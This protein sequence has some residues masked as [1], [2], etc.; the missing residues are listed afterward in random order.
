M[1]S[2]QSLGGVGP[3][4]AK[5]L[6][7]L[8]CHNVLSI[9]WHLPYAVQRR[10]Y[11]QNLGQAVPGE[12]ITF[13][14]EVLQHFP[15]S[16]R[17]KSGSKRPY[18]IA[19]GDSTRFLDLIFF[20]GRS[21]Y[22]EQNL[23]V[24]SQRL[25]S[26]RFEN[27]QGKL[28]ITHPDHV[29]SPESLKE[30]QGVEPVYALTQSLTQKQMRKIVNSA[31]QRVQALPEWISPHLLQK[32]QWQPWH[33]SLNRCHKP[34]EETDAFPSS[35]QRRRLAFDELLANQLA[36]IIVRQAHGAQNGQ[37]IRG[38]GEM[39]NKVRALLPF[40]LT[41]DQEQS[42]EEI[43]SDMESP[44]RMIRLLQG[45]VGAGKTIVAFLSLL[46][47]V[48]AGFQGALLAPTEILVKQHF[49]TLLPWAETAG[50]SLEILLGKDTA[51][52]KK[53]K[54]ERLSTGQI[55]I[56]VGTH[57]LVQEG[58]VFQNLGLIVVDEQHRFGVEQRLTLAEKGQRVD[59]LSMT[60]TPIPRTLMLAVYG[61]LSTSYLR[62]KPSGRQEIQ[63]KA[64]ALD[65]LEDVIDGI[66]RVLQEG[67]KI[68]WI[69]PLVEESEN[70]DLAAAEKRFE[71][72][73]LRFPGITG[74][75][76]GRI[77]GPER[78]VVMTQ[79]REGDL[80]ILVAT[81]VVEVGVHVEDA[82]IM[83]IEHAE[84]FGLSQLHQLRGRIGRGKRASTCILLYQNSSLS[85]NAKARLKIMKSTNDGFKIAEED[86][87]L[88][89]GG[90]ALGLKQSGM[91]VFH[92]ADLGCHHDLLAL[93][94]QESLDLLKRDPQL[95][96]AQGQAARLLLALFGRESATR[97]LKAG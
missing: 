96:S 79:F 15:S 33:E 6:E 39:Q 47:A 22:L 92:L 75:V 38:T 52:V 51:K 14:A 48:E 77:K 9:L 37:E 86:L 21:Q 43:K 68:Y 8:D 74:L 71:L 17:F 41:G 28:Q 87:R 82:T 62:Q 20:N 50:I 84:R 44:H 59:V 2:L 60:A 72:L 26:G 31:L 34:L 30:W 61:D 66:Q 89:G 73:N 45:D 13:Q 80:K 63:T 4:L 58:V 76:H 16:E 7:R 70:L 67:E 11:I 97:F 81:T 88:R 90:D 27:F 85:D 32:Y 3:S 94:Q 23:P 56:I 24:G 19:V 12:L 91:P 1:A 35:I 42:L 64:I 78:D 49:Q 69:C 25:I 36:I 46:K 53:D 57:A 65:R 5:V 95:M 83:V 93:A 29:G 54:Y 18:R 55:Q 10:H 40:Q